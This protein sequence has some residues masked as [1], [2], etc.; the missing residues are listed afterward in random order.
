MGFPASPAI[1]ERYPVVNPIWEWDGVLW[2]KLIKKETI[3]L[4]GSI[5]VITS[6]T[7]AVVGKHY[8][9][10]APGIM[11]TLPAVLPVKDACIAIT[12]TS[13][14]GTTSSINFGAVKMR[15]ASPGIIVLDNVNAEFILQS[16]GNTTYGWV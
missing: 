1:N 11:L 7:T 16:T 15:G 13:L 2:A 4:K 6:N 9:I 5:E 12:N 8:V 3:G 10:G 14:G